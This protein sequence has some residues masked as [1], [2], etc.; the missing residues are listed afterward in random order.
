M[1]EMR[2][3]TEHKF[4]VVKTAWETLE[5]P[6]G[7]RILQGYLSES[8]HPSIRIRIKG[9][10][11]FITIKGRSEGASRP[12]YEYEIPH[13]DAEDLL[14]LFSKTSVEKVR[15]RI[16]FAGKIWE[17]DEFLGDNEGLLLAEIELE[18]EGETFEKPP[19]AG[20]DVT[21]DPRYY[22][23]YLAKSPFKSWKK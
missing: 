19:W 14:H 10:Q 6:H 9:D 1:E 2:L 13:S 4:L 8:I 7:L 12:E 15:Y 21:G 22:N 16:S 23:S 20:E 3:E 5:K 18:D 11:G 17:V